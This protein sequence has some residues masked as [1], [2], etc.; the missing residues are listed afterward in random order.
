MS[1]KR[2][3]MDSN[4]NS[5]S[6]SNNNPNVSETTTPPETTLPTTIPLQT[7]NIASFTI[8]APIPIHVTV[9]LLSD[10]D[11][12]NMTFLQGSSLNHSISLTNESVASQDSSP[13][14]LNLRPLRL[15]SYEAV[16]VTPETITVLS[17]STMQLQNQ[18]QRENL[19]ELISALLVIHLE[20]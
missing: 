1:N 6:R 17:G 9:R 20:I 13:S 15:H 19:T 16:T 4:Y 7:N 3:R 14:E 8:S 11:L 5:P 10:N 18:M 2:Q 12:T